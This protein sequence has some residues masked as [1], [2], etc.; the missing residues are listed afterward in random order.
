[1]PKDDR[2]RPQRGRDP[3][4]QRLLDL[5]YQAR[6]ARGL[7]V[8]QLA[9]RAEI[10]P[11]YVSLIENG[12]KIPDASTIERIGRVLGLDRKLLNAWVTVRGRSAD[13]GEAIE[14]ARE[15]VEQLGLSESDDAGAAPWGVAALASPSAADSARSPGVMSPSMSAPPYSA[16]YGDLRLRDELRAELPDADRY[17]IGVPLVEE[18]MEPVGGEAPAADRRP[19]WIDRRSLPERDELRGAFAWRLSPKGLERVRGIYRRG[20]IVVISP[21]L[22]TPDNLDPKMVFAVRHA[23]RVVLGRVSWTGQDLVLL[24]SRGVPAVVI[25]ARNEGELGRAI[26]G[27][28]ILAVQR[29]R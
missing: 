19:L 27:R 24:P 14:A 20:D 25:A 18:G 9:D 21:L 29:F 22:W 6:K 13:T 10:S 4:T 8:R 7:T 16:G 3:V 17:V 15:L 5:L 1:M 28:V 23:D 11:S 26:A 2:S 12:H